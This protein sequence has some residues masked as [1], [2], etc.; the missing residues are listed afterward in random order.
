MES[1]FIK[2]FELS[3]VAGIIS[4]VI[5][6]VR[7]IFKRAPKWVYV[8]LW[9]LVAIRLILPFNIESK[10]SLLPSV[11][12]NEPLKVYESETVGISI[13]LP[14]IYSAAESA[15]LSVADIGDSTDPI[16][17]MLTAAANIWLLGIAAMLLYTV[18]S[19]W[20][21]KA[22]L[23][24]AV[25]LKDNIYLCDGVASPFI[26]GVIRPKIYLPS[27]I[28]EKDSEYVILHELAHLRRLDHIW[29]PLGFLLLSVYWFNPVLWM[30]YIFLCRDIE[31]ACDEKVIEEQGLDIKKGYSEA[32]INCSL[33][34]RQLSAC[35]LAFGEVQVKER[36]VKILNYKKPAFW[37]IAVS[38]VASIA[39]A[40]A[41]LTNPVQ[42]YPT[43]NNFGIV[44]TT[45]AAG[46]QNVKFEYIGSD[47]LADRPY[48]E[49]KWTNNRVENISFGEAFTIKKDGKLYE[50]VEE[51][52]F[53]MPAYI[54]RPSDSRIERLYLDAYK[55]TKGSY[56]V[57]K[58]FTVDGIGD[59]TALVNFTVGNIAAIGNKSYTAKVVEYCSSVAVNT[60]LVTD[61]TVENGEEGFS[62]GVSRDLTEP[63]RIDVGKILPIELRK[64]NF[65]KY[66]T[67]KASW[68]KGNSAAK[69]RRNTLNA[70]VS[71]IPNGTDSKQYYVLEQKS[72]EVYLAVLDTGTMA[73]ERAIKMEFS[74]SSDAEFD[75]WGLRMGV[76]LQRDR[77][78]D[79]YFYHTERFMTVKGKLTCSPDYE[80]RVIYN[81]EVVSFADYMTKVL[82]REYTPKT[83]TYNSI[84][85]DIYKGCTTKIPHILNVVESAAEL[86]DAEYLLLKKV[87]LETE[88]GERISRVYS[89]SFS[90]NKRTEGSTV[91]DRVNYDI[92]G[93]GKEESCTV[94]D[95]YTSGVYSFRFSVKED[96]KTEYYNC[97]SSDFY[98]LRFIEE[99]GRL[100]LR[101]VTQGEPRII[102]FDISF[103][104]GNILLTDSRGNTLSYFGEQGIS[105][106]K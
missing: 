5:F 56:S 62:L 94:G 30:S 33:P 78:L 89:G 100:K 99:D 93:D 80:I 87:V 28:G 57:E 58:K 63:Y 85:Y 12:T 101:G 97:F 79:A 98:Y 46:C 11:D 88:D 24:E 59:Y 47:L 77:E 31:L 38:L 44:G 81:N 41:F 91:I 10:M 52:Y 20:K 34:R 18:I 26:L 73:F 22:G 4:L 84:V 45:S 104:D 39:V 90:V 95:G 40:V 8:L 51:Q 7:L 9:G 74:F 105:A 42:K 66:F 76:S 82:G 75:E 55:F 49:V 60:D 48:I 21:I 6:C 2:A 27:N 50:P 106:E 69:L 72:G 19:Y 32:L 54:V 65:D 35:P 43:D 13:N 64:D 15:G 3:L 67:E 16:Q 25:A 53:N 14:Q 37:I 68:S 92:D 61:I 103:K 17:I 1:L 36:V 71:E 23:R 70:F 83:P 102:L 29:K 86:P 96:G